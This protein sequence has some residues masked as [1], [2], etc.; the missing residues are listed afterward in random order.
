MS[1]Q[2]TTIGIPELL[3]KVFFKNA[4]EN[5]LHEHTIV[6]KQM[7]FS[8][9]SGDGENYLSQIYRVLVKYTKTAGQ[10]DADEISVIVKVMPQVEGID[11]IDEMNIF[12]KEKWILLEMLPQFEMLLKLQDI[13]FAPRC[14]YTTNSPRQT[15]V[16]EDMDPLGFQMVNRE[17]GL[18]ERHAKLALKKLAQF[19][20]T[21][22]VFAKKRPSMMQHFNK[23][24][25]NRDAIK[26]STSIYKIFH[27]HLAHEIK[28]VSKWEEFEDILPKLQ[29]FYDDFDNRLFACQKSRKNEIT[30]LNHGDFWVN[31]LLFKYDE[32]NNPVD[33]VFLDFQL[34]IFGSPGID[35]NYFIFA[36]CQLEVTKKW[37]TLLEVYH[38][39]LRDAL[40]EL[41]YNKIPSYANIEREF[42]E[43]SPYGIMT[44]IGP[45]PVMSIN[46]NAS[47]GST[48]DS[49]AESDERTEMIFNNP[50]LIERLKYALLELDNLGAFEIDVDT[51]KSS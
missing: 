29:A 23:G 5:G 36:S 12:N 42:K 41:Q 21:S 51:N 2:S 43:K 33:L 4:L 26:P 22:M 13:Q 34:S 16:L 19:H 11:F 50:Y 39:S 47:E 40:K 27:K 9:G 28:I 3:D 32:R 15:L 17:I 10:V 46:K 45:L 1:T 24:L 25:L 48:F 44:I 30:V 14:Y 7:E 35:L 49:L 8:S 37:K 38:A 31:N 18:D 20:A 6:I